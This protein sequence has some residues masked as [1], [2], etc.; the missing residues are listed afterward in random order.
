MNDE[1]KR[2]IAIALEYES[3]SRDAPNVVA[4]G[5]GETAARIVALAK[6]HDIVI[7]T[8]PHLAEALSGIE[9]NDSIPLEL[10]EAV[11]EIIGFVL[12]TQNRMK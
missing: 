7:E 1:I 8:N 9:L 6:E 2:D 12:R 5:Y 4:K 11:A 10:Y 3:T